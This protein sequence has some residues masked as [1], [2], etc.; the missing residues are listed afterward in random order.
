MLVAISPAEADSWL[1]HLI[2]KKEKCPNSKGVCGI[3][4]YTITRSLKKYGQIEISGRMLS[5]IRNG[6]AAVATAQAGAKNE[7]VGLV[8]ETVEAIN[9]EIGSDYYIVL[10]CTDDAAHANLNYRHGNGTE[11]I[12]SREVIRLH[13]FFRFAAPGSRELDLLEGMAGIAI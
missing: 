1:H 12:V 11:I 5:L 8:Y 2:L 3:W 13:A 9:R 7:F 10:D 6:I 4:E